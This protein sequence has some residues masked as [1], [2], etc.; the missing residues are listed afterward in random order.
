M[1]ELIGRSTTHDSTASTWLGRVA[2]DVR[3]RLGEIPEPVSLT[4]LAAAQPVMQT[5]GEL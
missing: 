5:L 1:R 4:G 3:N 2:A